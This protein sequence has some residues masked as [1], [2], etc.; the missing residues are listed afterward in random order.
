MAGQMKPLGS[1]GAGIGRSY[2][3]RIS[4]YRTGG[5]QLNS[6][7]SIHLSKTD[8]PING[9]TLRNFSRSSRKLFKN[10]GLKNKYR[11]HLN[12]NPPASRGTGQTDHSTYS[13]H[14]HKHIDTNDLRRLFNACST[15]RRLWNSGFRLTWTTVWNGIFVAVSRTIT[16]PLPT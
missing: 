7:E 16:R 13:N 8:N 5:N 10:N 2:H 4:I 11:G 14:F 1:R 15:L 3:R 12:S 9:I 6:N